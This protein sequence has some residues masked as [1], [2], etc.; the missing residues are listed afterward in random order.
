[1]DR[2]LDRALKEIETACAAL[3]AAVGAED[4]E[5]AALGDQDLNTS[6]ERFGALLDDGAPLA[7]DALL[8][9]RDPQSPAKDSIEPVAV[10]LAC[11]LEHHGRLTERL[12]GARDAAGDKLSQLQKGRRG[13]THYLDTAGS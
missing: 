9:T 2:R 12:I 4:W 3:E 13:A 1:M 10:R 6:L 11:V 7:D 8:A 5:A